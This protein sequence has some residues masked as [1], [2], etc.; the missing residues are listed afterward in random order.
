MVKSSQT[1]L[2]FL[3]IFEKKYLNSIHNEAYILTRQLT[4]GLQFYWEWPHPLQLW[5]I[6]VIFWNSGSR[7]LQV[8]VLIRSSRSRV[9]R[10]KIDYIKNVRIRVFLVRIFPHS[11]WIRGNPLRIQSKCRKI[12]TRKILNTTQKEPWFSFLMKLKT[13]EFFTEHPWA[14]ASTD[15]CYIC[16][17]K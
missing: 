8:V 3:T 15:Y 11:D 9:F 2:S 7:Y 1:F 5:K 13:V 17:N 14:T 10:K 4:V 6:Y 16:N 12:R